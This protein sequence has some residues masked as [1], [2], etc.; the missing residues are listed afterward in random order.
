MGRSD[1]QPYN[2]SNPDDRSR[3]VRHRVAADPRSAAR[4]RADFGVWLK[5]HFALGADRFSDVVLAVNEAIANAAEFAYCDA[6]RHGTLDLSASYDHQSDTLAVTVDDRGRWREKVPVQ[7]HQ[8]LR[9]RGIPLMR[10]LADEVAIDR[11]PH[12][13]RVAMIWTGLTRRP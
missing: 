7:H 9:G 1:R 8:Q 11:T 2:A 10:A 12:G 13:T 3:F 5:T 4:V 6:A